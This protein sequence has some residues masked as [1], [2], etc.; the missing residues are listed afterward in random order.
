MAAGETPAAI[1][2]RTGS[3][4]EAENV[5]VVNAVELSAA[6]RRGQEVKLALPQAY[7]PRGQ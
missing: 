2:K 5:A 6:F 3:T 4:W 1:A 7:T